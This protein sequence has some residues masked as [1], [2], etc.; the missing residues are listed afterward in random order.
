MRVAVELAEQSIAILLGPFG[1]SFDKVLDLL[2]TSFPER[3]GTAEV[4]GVS[5]YEFGIELVLA[6]DLAKAV[7]DLGASAVAVRVLW[8]EL[9]ARAR[10]CPDF[11]DRAETDAVGFAE[12]SVDGSGFGHPHFCPADE[13]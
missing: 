5:L 6:D 9:L 10:N 13:R 12:G 1:E 8:R 11:L 7:A 3:L 4:D 2:P